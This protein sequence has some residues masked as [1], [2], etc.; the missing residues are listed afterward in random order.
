[1][2]LAVLDGVVAAAKNTILACSLNSETV[3]RFLRSPPRLMF[4]FVSFVGWFQ[5]TL[6]GKSGVCPS[7]FVELLPD[8]VIAEDMDKSEKKASTSTSAVAESTM[9]ELKEKLKNSLTHGMD[10]QS[11][12]SQSVLSPAASS[13]LAASEKKDGPGASKSRVDLNLSNIEIRL[14]DFQVFLEF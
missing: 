4:G 5:A 8:A 3:A 7:N 9:K 12:K 11:V 14:L 2:T 1:V 13:V 10:P 6:N